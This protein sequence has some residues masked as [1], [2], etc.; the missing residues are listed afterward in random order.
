MG[1]FGALALGFGITGTVH[2]GDPQPQGPNFV[3]HEGTNYQQY[4]ARVSTNADGSSYSVSYNSGQDVIARMFDGSGNPT[5]PDL[6]VHPGFSQYIQDEAEVCVAEGGEWLVAYSDRFGYDGEQMG[7]LGR[8]YGANGL[9]LG[10]VQQFNEVGAASQWRPLIAARK[11]GGWVVTWSGDWDGDAFF[12]LVEPNGTFATGDVRIATH[13]NGAQV[14]PTVA[15]SPINGDIFTVHVD[16]SAWGGV[17][18]GTN[19]WAR[20]FDAQGN[21]K[22]A[23]EIFVTPNQGAGDQR[24]PRVAADGLGNY[25]VTWQC[26]TTDGSGWGV[27]GRRYGPDGLPLGPE[28]PIPESTNFP[29]K[30]AQVAAD[31]AGNFVVVWE[32]WS[33]GHAEIMAR[34][35]DP[36]GQPQ[37]G[38]F[39]VNEPD[40]NNQIRPGLAMPRSGHEMMVTWDGPGNQ[41]DCYGRLFDLSSTPTNPASYCTPK[42][43][44]NGCLATTDWRGAP[45]LTG[46]D[47]FRILAADVM[48]QRNGL[49]FFGYAPNN[50]PWKGGTLCVAPP[51]IRTVVQSSGGN[52]PPLDC[53]G[54]FAFPFTQAYMGQL[55]LGVGTTV[56]SQYWYRDPAQPDGTG[57][58]LS[59]GLRFTIE[60]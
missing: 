46:A 54:A 12:R 5:T 19:L 29:Q 23:T 7:I 49:L 37:G 15:V 11:G 18:S 8:R 51:V 6:F 44:S 53:S 48:S 43:S 35:F 4:W 13:D 52:P 25:I 2:A 58:S 55:G 59:N 47:D 21:P 34:A 22:Q 1:L 42:A 32:D 14:D 39:L 45:T 41:T 9:P 3:I 28:F 31:D 24:E 33:L 36:T 60:P 26:D 16:F 50:L 56:Y 20:L 57:T 17:G 10:N 40:P 27:F 30:N 38:E